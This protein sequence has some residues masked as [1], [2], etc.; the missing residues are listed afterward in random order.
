M[1]SLTTSSVIVPSHVKGIQE[2]VDSRR[3]AA[4]VSI[5]QGDS[6]GIKERWCLRRMMLELSESHLPFTTVRQPSQCLSKLSS[7]A[8]HFRWPHSRARCHVCVWTEPSL[9]DPSHV[10]VAFQHLTGLY[11]SICWGIHHW[12]RKQVAEL[13]WRVHRRLAGRRLE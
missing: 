5:S 3:Q 8:W 13:G 12:L 2:T 9:V 6:A 4:W 10:F 1:A 7:R 11:P